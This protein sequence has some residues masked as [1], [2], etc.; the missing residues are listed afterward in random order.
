MMI[1]GGLLSAALL[2]VAAGAPAT[3]PHYDHIFVIIEE[4]HTADQIIGNPAAPNLTRLAKTFGYASEFYAERHPSEPNYVA[5]LGGDTFGIR[6]DDAF[7][8]KAQTKDWGCP[9]SGA[10][11]YVDHT[12]TAPGLTSQLAA[13]H[14]TWKG[15]FED[16][17]TPGS[18]VYRWPVP[19]QPVPGKPAELYA[20][21]HN[22]FMNFRDVQDDPAIVQKVVGFDILARD[23]AS[24]NVANYVQIV[25]NQCDDM[26]GVKAAEAP[27]DCA[28]KNAAALIGRGDSDAAKLVDEITR[29]PVWSAPGNSAIV[30]TFDE[31]DDDT[32]SGH[33]DGCCGSGLQDKDN[34]GGGWIPTIVITNH[35]PRG[36]VD[37]TPY[38]HYSLLRTTEDALGIAEHLGHAADADKGVRDMTP[39]FAAGGG[40]GVPARTQ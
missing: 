2:A 26:H 9:H 34:P 28:K 19:G 4:N 21:K 36:A 18:R 22:G 1:S 3:M 39:L 5:M 40:K 10:A 27:A 33:P 8:C 6:D 29:S 25:P 23:L 14:L 15:Y 17:P 16:I 37:P 32:P 35:G 12:V 20:V 31:N 24:G 38:N 13:H 30:I 7:Y 11:G